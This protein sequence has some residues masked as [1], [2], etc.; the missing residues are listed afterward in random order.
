MTDLRTEL[1]AWCLS[2][3]AAFNAE[4][5]ESIAAHWSF[6]ALTT[7]V[8]RSFTF[9]SEEHF[10]R[11]TDVLLGFYR[12]QNVDR[13]ER[14]LV[15]CHLLHRDAA[16]MVVSDA[17]YGADGTQIASW[18][19]AYV[20]QRVNGAWRAVMAVADGETEAWAARGTPLGG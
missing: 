12:A 20:L 9:K 11:N 19:A 14:A 1:E 8:G 6:P 4:N 18:Q 3:V 17:M 2:Y 10:A 13:V 5:A 7:Q 15:E 16:S